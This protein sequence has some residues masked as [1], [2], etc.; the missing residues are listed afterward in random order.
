MYIYSQINQSATPSVP[1]LPEDTM[2]YLVKL[3]EADERRSFSM[4][5]YADASWN[6]TPPTT[7]EVLQNMLRDVAGIGDT[8]TFQAWAGANS[9]N[10]D[11]KN[12]ERIFEGLQRDARRLRK[13]FGD[14]EYARVMANVEDYIG[15]T[16]PNIIF[17]TPRPKGRPAKNNA[18]PEAAAAVDTM[19]GAVPPRKSAVKTATAPTGTFT[20]VQV[21]GIVEQAVN[22]ALKGFTKAAIGVSRPAAKAAAKA[23][24]KAPTAKKVAATTKTATAPAVNVKSKTTR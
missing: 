7:L 6:G 9:R 4:N 20:E 5:F 15:N 3:I 21:R 22:A 2:E 10:V 18:Q 14:A 1:N 13:F 16:L 8:T 19:K 24:K 12:D 11:S 17:A 23:P